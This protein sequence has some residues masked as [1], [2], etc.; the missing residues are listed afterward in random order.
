MKLLTKEI[1]RTMPGP[2]AQENVTDPIVH[3]KFFHPFSSWAWFATEAW[4]I[5]EV[6]DSDDYKEE[7]LSYNL[8]PGEALEDIIFFGWVHGDFPELGT[9]SFNELRSVRKHGLGIERDLHFQPK[10]LSEVQNG[11]H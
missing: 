11:V 1:R 6:Q 3:V 7:P 8:Q 5:I 4:Q 9:F 2:R 10:P